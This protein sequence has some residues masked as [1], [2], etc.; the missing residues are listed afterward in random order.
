MLH[1]A[2][3][4]AHNIH[5]QALDVD[6][7]ARAARRARSRRVLWFTGLS[8]A[9]KSTIANLVEKKLHAAGPAHLPARRRQ[10]PPRPQPRP[11]LHRRRPGREHP[12]RRR[13]G[14]AD[15]R[16]RPDRAGLVHL[17]VPRR[18]R[19]WRA[20]LVRRGRVRRGLRRHAARRSPSS[21]TSR[22]STRRRARG[23]LTNFTGIDSPYEPPESARD[24]R[25]HR[26]RLERGQ[27][28]DLVIARM[29]ELGLLERRRQVREPRVHRVDERDR[30][31]RRGPDRG[32]DR[33]GRRRLDD[34]DPAAGVG[35]AP[36]A[37]VGTDLWS[38]RSPRCRRR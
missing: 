28:A 5:W 17:A 10:R 36:A 3:R 38:P 16:R 1:F 9:G 15:G 29:R 8:G 26:R 32:S 18:A 27:A 13:G 30:R 25:R 37:A 24:P 12:P 4:R 23:E 34:A 19:A 20:T 14:Q 6:K 33:R 21:A 31:L 22:A 2:L 11:R 35:M 7:A